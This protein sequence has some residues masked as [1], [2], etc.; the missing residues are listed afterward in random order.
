MT[1]GQP[2][3]DPAAS[4]VLADRSAGPD[5]TPAR[6]TTF[7]LPG[8]PYVELTL[9]GISGTLAVGACTVPIRLS[10]PV[11]GMATIDMRP[12]HLTL[13]AISSAAG[14]E[15]APDPLVI[16]PASLAAAV[17]G[18][19]VSHVRVRVDLTARRLTAVG[20]DVVGDRPWTLLPGRL[21]VTDLNLS[22]NVY[23]HGADGV[24]VS[25][26]LTG[27]MTLGGTA[28]PV[29]ASPV[30]R[31]LEVMDDSAHSSDPRQVGSLG[32]A[33]AVVAGQPGNRSGR[34]PGGGRSS[35][36]RSTGYH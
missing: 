2:V 24:K 21:A 14:P 12:G 7:A 28:V 32:R 31:D 13:D 33:G 25:G 18:A 34:T 30:R 16:L 22:V 9:Q 29:V 27:T 6:P 1:I 10:P 20:L 4:G 5:I 3:F 17:G 15:L 36:T 26:A 19:V 11:D 8:V 35:W 23:S